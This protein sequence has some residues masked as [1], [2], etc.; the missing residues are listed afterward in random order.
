MDLNSAPPRHLQRLAETLWE[1]RGLAAELLYRLR[2]A[3]LLLAADDQRFVTRAIDQVEVATG[4]LR[5]A[6]MQREGIVLDVAVALGGDA[7]MLTL[8][9]LAS[10][11]AEPWRSVFADH[12][13]AFLSLAR[14]IEETSEAG[15]E[16]SGRALGRVRRSITTL[17]GAEGVASGHHAGGRR[18]ATAPGGPP[19]LHRAL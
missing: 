6:E 16:L 7:H 2:C 10:H 3:H 9:T 15:R 18:G 8:E 5:H 14:E 19:R 4:R 11:T 13:R 17:A 12:R 1:E